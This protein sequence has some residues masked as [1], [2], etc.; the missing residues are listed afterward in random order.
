MR[1]QVYIVWFIIFI[2]WVLFR[3]NFYFPEWI[4]EL[5]VKPLI[6]VV[7][8]LAVVW[9]WENRSLKELGLS[10]NWKNLFL[11]LYIAVVL[12]VLFAIEG[13]LSNYIKYGQFSF[14][15]IASAKLYQS[16]EYFLL[17]N[18][19][20]SVSEEILGRGFLYN[21]LF[22]IS[23]HQLW[24]AVVSSFLFLL[25]HIPIMFTRIHLTGSALVMYP[26]SIMIMGITNS[27]L[28]TLRRSLVLPILLHTF[29]NM[30]VALYL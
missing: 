18:L 24:A 9:V 22:K 2:L 14:A 8:V 27:Y 29:W 25:L 1:R 10:T 23:K 19:V 16:I 12:G 21:R 4:D 5:I 26:L 15:P 20:T 13:L 3:A 6:F 17:I 11:D 30:T 28:F 7:P